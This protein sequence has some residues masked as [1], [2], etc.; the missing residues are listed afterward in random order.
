MFCTINKC[1]VYLYRI[2]YEFQCKFNVKICIIEKWVIKFQSYKQ[3]KLT[4]GLD[5]GCMWRKKPTA[6]TF[7]LW[8][9]LIYNVFLIYDGYNGLYRI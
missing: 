2:N 1:K 8:P 9:F 4:L 3:T 5:Y 6:K 7:A